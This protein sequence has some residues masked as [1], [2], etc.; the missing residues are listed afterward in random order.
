MGRLRRAAGAALSAFFV[1][2]VL[3]ASCRSLPPVPDGTD[4]RIPRA[5]GRII[6]YGDT[7]G[8]TRWGPI[9]LEGFIRETDY[10]RERELV[11]AR[12][13]EEKPDL[14]VHSGD[15]ISRGSSGTEWGAWDASSAGLRAAKIPLFL[16]WGNH[17][18]FLDPGEAAIHIDRRFPHLEGRHWYAVRYDRLLVVVLD[19]NFDELPR[20]D[21]SRQEAWLEQTLARADGD[22]GLAAVVL[23][24]H[25]SPYTNSRV[26]APDEQVQKRFVARARKCSKFRA[27]ITGHVHNYERFLVD[28]A[29]FVVAG[30]GGAPKTA[31]NRESPRYPD[32]FD[33]PEVRP[34]QYCLVTV[35]PERIAVDVVMLNEAD[36]TW[37]RGDGFTLD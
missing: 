3:S 35:G 1:L 15:V 5:T 28:G 37:Y 6:V 9:N 13:L 11:M 20:S 24:C 2:L 17:E 16:A 23:V 10:A 22:A 8:A 12:L 27:M 18:Y 36:G 34:F 14:I 26:H 19:S 30:G 31:V 32:L 29:H 7:R 33:G 25:H 21:R 4:Y